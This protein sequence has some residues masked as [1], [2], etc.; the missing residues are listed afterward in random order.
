M[1]WLGNV[2]KSIF[3]CNFL[4]F[5]FLLMFI[6]FHRNVEDDGG[7]EKRF[8]DVKERELKDFVVVFFFSKKRS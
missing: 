2:L 8:Q 4:L 3:V 7:D 5:F 1:M 6:V